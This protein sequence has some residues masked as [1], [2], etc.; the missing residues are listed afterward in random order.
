MNFVHHFGAS[1]RKQKGGRGLF[2]DIGKR[3][4]SNIGRDYSV[5]VLTSV[6]LVLELR[7]YWIP[8]LSLAQRKEEAK[9][10]K[11]KGRE[12]PL[13]KTTADRNLSYIVTSWRPILKS[14]KI[15]PTITKTAQAL[16]IH[17]N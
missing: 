13:P 11:E 10:E 2:C 9:R 5:L 7:K 15:Q 12:K 17:H 6:E 14:T 4:N 3:I 8:I 16:R 1:I